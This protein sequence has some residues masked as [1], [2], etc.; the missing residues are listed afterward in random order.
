MQSRYQY[1]A[2]CLAIAVALSTAISAQAQPSHAAA[3]S[4]AAPASVPSLAFDVVSIRRN[5]SGTHEMTRQSSSNTD[6][7]SMTNVPLALVVL[8]A[9]WISDP[10]MIKGLPDQAWADRYDVTAKV[11]PESLAAYHALTSRQ[12]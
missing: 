3:Q 10:N 5:T 8:Y 9:Y 2:P 4:S 11:A 1:L 6:S 7:I 12:R